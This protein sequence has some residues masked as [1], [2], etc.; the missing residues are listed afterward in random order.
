MPAY[1]PKA[2]D[3]S[4]LPSWAQA[5]IKQFSGSIDPTDA[6]NP[7][8]SMPQVMGGPAG[9]LAGMLAGVAFPAGKKAFMGLSGKVDKLKGV[10]HVADEPAFASAHANKGPN[11][12]VM[13][14]ELDVKNALDLTPPAI[15]GV[16]GYADAA[17]DL[18]KIEPFL[19]ADDL[20]AFKQAK[21]YWRGNDP[22]AQFEGRN[23]MVQ[24]LVDRLLANNPAALADAGFDGIRYLDG[25]DKAAGAWAVPDPNQV[26]NMLTHERGVGNVP[27]AAVNPREGAWRQWAKDH[28][29][30]FVGPNDPGA[31]PP[32]TPAELARKRG[33]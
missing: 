2:P 14:V 32:L 5:A 16:H 4:W 9:K 29:L 6:V 10:A 24:L 28:G 26:M 23:T 11:P 20:P 18:R 7:T 3:Y 15:G 17:G 8:I 31:L 27:G 25:A 1:S 22:T 13:P 12:S 19:P 30:G 21:A 33:R